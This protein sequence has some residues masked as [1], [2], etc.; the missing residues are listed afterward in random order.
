MKG[1]IKIRKK[2][3]AILNTKLPNNL[4]YHGAHHSINALQ[5]CEGYLKHEKINGDR[6]KL[7]RIG[8]LLHDIGFTVSYVN[9][10]NESVKIALKLMNDI[11]SSKEDIRIVKKL[12]LATKLPQNPKSQLEKI[13]CDVDLDYLGGDKY[14]EISNQL[15]KELKI[16]SRVDKIE[17]WN[18]IQLKFLESHKYHTNFAIH[19]RQPKKEKRIEELKLLIAINKKSFHL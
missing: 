14:Y 10:E 7:L 2:A 16:F 1:Y 17:K 3:L 4:Y 11:G 5:V 8:I 18:K 9:H 6:A 15:F 13:I 19:N 12:I